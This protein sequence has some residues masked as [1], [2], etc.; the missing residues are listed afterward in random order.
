MISGWGFY[1][2]GI[3]KEEDLSGKSTCIG[4]VVTKQN[5]R[6]IIR[7]LKSKGSYRPLSN[8]CCSPINSSLLDL[9]VKIPAM[10]KNA[11]GGIG[12]DPVVTTA[13]I[14]STGY[15]AYKLAQRLFQ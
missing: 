12:T 2:S 13:A 11:N 3:V 4:S 8:N 7:T 5:M 1:P 9:G 15:F 6:N 10:I 14:A